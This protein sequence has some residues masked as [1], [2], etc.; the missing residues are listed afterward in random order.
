MYNKPD[1]F[2]FFQ[3]WLWGVYTEFS[4]D[5]GWMSRSS[6]QQPEISA[7]VFLLG[8]YGQVA[9]FRFKIGESCLR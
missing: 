4:A 3:S 9:N 6:V 8:M 1:A 2:L 7:A 5:T